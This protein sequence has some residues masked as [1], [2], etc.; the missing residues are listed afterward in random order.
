MPSWSTSTVLGGGFVGIVRP[1]ETPS[2]PPTTAFSIVVVPIA[3]SGAVHGCAPVT[4]AEELTVVA[5]IVSSG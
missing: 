5:V 4:V 3:E 2:V 1:N